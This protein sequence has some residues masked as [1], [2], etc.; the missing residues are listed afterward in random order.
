[1]KLQENNSPVDREHRQ[2]ELWQI[3]VPL[4]VSALIVIGLGILV[5]NHFNNQADIQK[6]SS[7]ALIWLTAPA[8]ILSILLLVTLI[9]IIFLV[10]KLLD[11]LPPYAKIAEHAIDQGKMKIESVTNAAVEPI[12]R[13]NTYLAG[14]RALFKRK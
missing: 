2:Q 4:L 8:L 3:I 13:L 11:I 14:L 12:L 1:M 9:G 7:A 5:G 6:W 10:T